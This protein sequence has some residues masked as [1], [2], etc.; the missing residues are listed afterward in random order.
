VNGRERFNG[1]VRGE[2]KRGRK[3]L[4]ACLEERGGKNKIVVLLY[5]Y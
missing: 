3:N 1:R 5:P 4:W 2:R